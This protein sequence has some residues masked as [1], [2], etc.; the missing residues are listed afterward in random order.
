[1]LTKHPNIIPKINHDLNI[2]TIACNNMF[3]ET[4]HSGKQVVTSYIHDS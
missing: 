3:V 1:M 4:L 2:L